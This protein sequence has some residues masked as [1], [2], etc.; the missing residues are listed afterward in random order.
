[1][2]LSCHAELE[3]DCRVGQ[4][5]LVQRDCMRQGSQSRDQPVLTLAVM[6]VFFG[7]TSFF[8]ACWL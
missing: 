1:M 4:G 5:S 2:K 6:C 3:L 7:F 8:V